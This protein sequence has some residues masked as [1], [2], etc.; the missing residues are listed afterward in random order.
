MNS[1]DFLIT[2]VVNALAISVTS[3][4]LPGIYIEGGSFVSLLIVALVFGLVNAFVRPL[5]TILSLPFIVVTLGLFLVVINGLML[6]FVAWL[7]PLQVNGF[8][9]G[10]LG[11]IVMGVIGSIFQSLFYRNTQRVNTA[12]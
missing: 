4:L 7:T 1:R 8:W 9:W 3:W 11:A 10:V 12:R 2:L 6:M 5:I